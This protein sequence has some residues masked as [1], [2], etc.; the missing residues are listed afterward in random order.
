MS[1]GLQIKKYLVRL[2]LALMVAASPA[3]LTA[4]VSSP[5]KKPA[6]QISAP[7][8]KLGD[9]ISP[10]NKPGG[11]IS[12]PNKP[13]GGLPLQHSDRQVGRVSVAVAPGVRLRVEN[14]TSGRITV[15]G[16]DGD[17]IEAHAVSERGEEVVMFA[18]TGGDEVVFLKADYVNLNNPATPTQALD[19][20]PLGREGPIQVHLEV[21]VPRYA[22]LEPT[23]VTR[24]NVEIIGVETPIT[25]IG[26][27]SNITLEDVGSVEAH[28][29]TG[30]ILVENAKGIAD[31]TSST[32]AIKISNS[33]GA[34]RAVSIAGSIEIRCFKGRI[35]VSNTQALIELEAIEGDVEAIAASSDVSFK[36]RLSDD[37][38]YYLKSMSGRV[39]M[40]LPDDTRGFNATLTSYR[41]MVESDFSL[42]P[43][44]V[45]QDISTTGHRLS[46]RFGKGSPQITLDS[47]EGLVK[48]SKVPSTSIRSCR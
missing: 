24:S 35:D 16:W 4:Q 13:A 3:L 30:S 12:P 47:F 29:R 37:G 34:V 46:G 22:E 36:G 17:T 2:F 26:H 1:K 48:L 15:H 8:K 20:P 31:V 23:R 21:N 10:P 44:P 25:V 41:G 11:Q 14:R 7:P 43:K 6:D 5:P 40:R 19:S 28:T 18:Q 38:R 9:Q 27:S 42:H 45:A 32:G 39:E 33:S